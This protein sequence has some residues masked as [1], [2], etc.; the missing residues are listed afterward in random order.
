MSFIKC[1]ICFALVNTD[2]D[3]GF[4]DTP[5]PMCEACRDKIEGSCEGHPMPQPEDK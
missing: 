3:P 2:D 5:I 1:P 4:F